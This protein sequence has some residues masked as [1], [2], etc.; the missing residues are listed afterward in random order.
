MAELGKT[1]LDLAKLALRRADLAANVRTGAG[2]I[3][4]EVGWAATM[5]PRGLLAKEAKRSTEHVF[6]QVVVCWS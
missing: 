3:W 2:L 4:A 5:L 1:K 6:K